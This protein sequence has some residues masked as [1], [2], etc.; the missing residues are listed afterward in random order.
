MTA[1][2]SEIS[3][4]NAKVK[5]CHQDLDDVMQHLQHLEHVHEMSSGE[6]SRSFA[7][8]ELPHE[9]DFVE[10]FAY[11]EMSRQLLSRIRELEHELGDVL[12]QKLPAPA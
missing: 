4:L 7:S 5:S 3:Q 8:A 1:T 2:I 12:E 11:L 6:F 10:W 9:T